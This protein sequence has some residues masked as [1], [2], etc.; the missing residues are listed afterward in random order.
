VRS[1][2][3]HIDMLAPPSCIG[4]VFAARVCELSCCGL[5]SVVVG[6]ICEATPTQEYCNQLNCTVLYC[7]ALHCAVSTAAVQVMPVPYL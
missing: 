5:V 4:C 6:L 1:H 3:R 2:A 7:T